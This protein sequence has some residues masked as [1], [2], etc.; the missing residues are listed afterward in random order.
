M[1]LQNIGMEIWSAEGP[2]VSFFGF[3]YPTRMA[4]VR[5]QDGTLFVWSPI[6]LADA[7]RA[8]V[9]A[10]GAV[11]HLVS[12][13]KLHHFWLGD[14]QTTYPEARLYA[15]PGL[16]RKRRD[17]TFDAELGN[18]PEPAWAADLDQVRF[19]GSFVLTEIVFLHFASRT[20]LFADL[21]QHFP[22]GWFKGWRGLVARW[23]GIV[24]PDYGAPRE[25]RA[26]FWQRQPA[27]QALQRILD[28]APDKVIIAHGDM[29]HENGTAFIRT[30]FRWLLR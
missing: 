26:S 24:H 20:A 1:L 16:R 27:R 25:W 3:A 2:V 11:A 4:V 7:L 21:L 13:N 28:F 8:E 23:D 30:G 19:A 9:D 6:P 10:L 29:A 18:V 17:L 5:L 12:P 14:W 15:S 22:P